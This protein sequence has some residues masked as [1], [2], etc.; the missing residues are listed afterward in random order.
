V[1][2]ALLARGHFVRGFDR[3][4]SPIG[5]ESHVGDLVDAVA[6]RRAVEGMDAMVHLAAMPD[7]G[8]FLTQLVPNN[9]IGLYHVLEAAREFHLKRVVLA[10]SIR[11]GSAQ[12]AAGRPI[13]RTDDATCPHD[14]YAATKVFAEAMGQTYSHQHKLSIVV[15]RIGWFI[16]N[17]MELG[18]AMKWHKP[19]KPFGGY[20]S[21]DDAQRFFT[22]AVEADRPHGQCAILYAVSKQAPGEGCDLD[23]GRQLIGYEPQDEFPNGMNLES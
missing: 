22:A 9:I 12:H 2:P 13:S 1:C 14:L 15:V 10:S 7:M 6:V 19:G 21:H 20:L 8:D 3:Q 18:R 11:A 4:P 16:R 17:R 23:P 5:V